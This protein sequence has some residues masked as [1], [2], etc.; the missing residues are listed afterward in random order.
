MRQLNNFIK[1]NQNQIN[2]MKKVL[3]KNFIEKKT[4]FSEKL[5]SKKF[6]AKVFPRVKGTFLKGMHG[7]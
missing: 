7:N 4:K 1:K 5:L 3:L 6:I 2:S